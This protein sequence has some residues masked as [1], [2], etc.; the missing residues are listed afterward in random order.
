M[1]KNVIDYKY[2]L[3]TC[4]V[5]C[6][7]LQFILF[8]GFFSYHSSDGASLLGFYRPKFGMVVGLLRV[9]DKWA[10]VGSG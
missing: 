7:C 6:H 3:F 2:R 8:I 4:C 10:R 5:I 1:Y 9:T